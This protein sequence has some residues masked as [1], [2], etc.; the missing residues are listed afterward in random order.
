MKFWNFEIEFLQNYVANE[1]IPDLTKTLDEIDEIAISKNLRYGNLN[2]FTNSV[3]FTPNKEN[4]K[5][6]EINL[7]LNEKTTSEILDEI[8]EGIQLPINIAIGK[9]ILY[10]YFV[11]SYFE[12]KRTL[13]IIFRFLVCRVFK[14]EWSPR[15]LPFLRNCF[16][17]NK[18]YQ[19]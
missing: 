10:I 2:Y 1:K 18:V 19:K 11:N 6:A 17:S 8:F 3:V 12:K 14:C 7:V 15:Y 9:L 13:K 4:A 5:V 16:K